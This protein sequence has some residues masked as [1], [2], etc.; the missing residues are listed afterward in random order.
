[1]YVFLWFMSISKIVGAQPSFYSDIH[2]G[3]T[4]IYE[5]RALYAE[6]RRSGFE[7]RARQTQTTFQDIQ[8]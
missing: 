2:Q 3:G 6:Y 4:E 5:E 1:M 8:L 7:H